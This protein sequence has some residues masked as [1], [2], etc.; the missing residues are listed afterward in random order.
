MN[1]CVSPAIPVAHAN[2]I[3][4]AWQIGGR[5][6]DEL[7]STRQLGRQLAV[8]VADEV[9]GPVDRGHPC[10]GQVRS[11]LLPSPV[12]EPAVQAKIAQ[13]HGCNL[14]EAGWLAKCAPSER[15]YIPHHQNALD[16]LPPRDYIRL[17]PQLETQG[18]SHV[19]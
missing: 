5:L 6:G 8:L 14:S 15:V 4:H 3:S 19:E 1:A 11:A 17:K 18:A 9:S 12:G 2:P 10:N 13:I 16:P 7:Q